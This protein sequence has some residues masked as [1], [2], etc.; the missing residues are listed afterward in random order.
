VYTFWIEINPNS[1]NPNLI[2][3]NPINPIRPVSDAAGGWNRHVVPR[4]STARLLS[5]SRRDSQP[6]A[7]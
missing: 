6:A 5:S 2:N 3:P 4:L 1:I 7:W